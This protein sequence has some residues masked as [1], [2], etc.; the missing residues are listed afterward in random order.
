MRT[1]SLFFIFWGI[2]VSP[3]GYP[4]DGAAT[5][6]SGLVG[7][8]PA[9]AKVSSWTDGDWSLLQ[10]NKYTYSPTG[11]T[12][13]DGYQDNSGMNWVYTYVFD[14]HDRLISKTL[15][16]GAMENISRTLYSYDEYGSRT[17]TV[18]EVW[19]EGRWVTT[20]KIDNNYTYVR[21]LVKTQTVL[22]YNTETKLME[23][24]YRLSY[25]YDNQ[26]L[27]STML[28]EAYSSEW[29]NTNF[30]EY[31]WMDAERLDYTK[32][33]RWLNGSWTNGAHV[34]YSYGPNGSKVSTMQDWDNLS[35]TYKPYN[36]MSQT[37][38]DHRNLISSTTEKWNDAWELIYGHQ[39]TLTYLE[40]HAVQRIDKIWTPGLPGLNTGGGGWENY[41]KHEYSDFQSLGKDEVINSEF[42]F[43]C[44][45]NPVM[46]QLELLYST[47][48]PG[49]MLF[50]MVDLMGQILRQETVSNLSGKISW[51]LASVPSGYYFIRLIDQSGQVKTRRIIKN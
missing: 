28:R 25:E 51:N 41:R 49:T 17:S 44:Y 18:D 9:T 8:Y 42:L 31:F 26:N 3:N 24:N 32:T 12:L 6:K 48:V 45:P 13:T 38:D 21:E 36:R 34:Q 33:S 1:S 4:Q 22:K 39:Y 19:A 46:G 20:N 7:D 30:T 10:E 35:G 37:Y 50:E 29:V 47:P 43:S 5:T 15:T 23:N 40:G 27:P 2:L 16:N 11:K 14:D